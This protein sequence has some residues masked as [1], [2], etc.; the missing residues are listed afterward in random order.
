ML[1]LHVNR[2]PSILYTYYMCIFVAAK[3]SS[4]IFHFMYDLG[5]VILFSWKRKLGHLMFHVIKVYKGICPVHIHLST[6]FSFG[7]LLV[8]VYDPFN[9]FKFK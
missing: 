4:P 2:C 9:I 8:N 3:T 6:L 5:H 7:T 1:D